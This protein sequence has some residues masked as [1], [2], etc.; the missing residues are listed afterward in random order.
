MKQLLV[1]TGTLVEGFNSALNTV[2]TARAVEADVFQSSF[3]A[4]DSL[5]RTTPQNVIK[6]TGWTALPAGPLTL[7]WTGCS[8]TPAITLNDAQVGAT[9]PTGQGVKKLIFRLALSH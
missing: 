1:F 9:L 4:L 8:G 5:V 6:M 7:T 2:N 3:E